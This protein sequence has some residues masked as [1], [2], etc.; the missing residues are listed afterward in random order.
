MSDRFFEENKLSY[1]TPETN[2]KMAAL[3]LLRHKALVNLAGG[4]MGALY[5][6]DI[7]DILVVAGLPVIVPNEVNIPE[8]D[9]INTK[10]EEEE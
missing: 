4:R 3:K 5:I 1:E 9:I 2:V 7:N 6:D 8:L 10:K